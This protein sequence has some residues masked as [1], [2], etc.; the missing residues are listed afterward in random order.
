M[1]RAAAAML[2][3]VIF[4][5]SQ[6]CGQSSGRNL[7]FDLS[8]IGFALDGRQICE[9]KGR[10][11]DYSSK[12]MDQIIAAGPK[13]VPVLIGMITDARTPNTKELII[14]YWYGMAIGDIAFC[15][16]GDVFTDSTGGKTTM[17]G[18]GWNDML[19][20]DDKRSAGEQFNDFIKKHGRKAVQPKWQTLWNR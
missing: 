6:L 20:P 11:Q 3:I 4:S 13:S 2:G 9:H 12:V 16:L 10:L 1:K 18:A 8:R 19:G 7:H 17:S 15:A 14:C 5:A